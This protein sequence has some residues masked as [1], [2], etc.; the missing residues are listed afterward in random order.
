VSVPYGGP[1]GGPGWDPKAQAKADKAYRKA[2]RPF[3]KKKRFILPVALLALI[4]IGVASNSGGSSQT[5][6]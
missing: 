3:Y 1:P 6:H 5:R 4:V 2:Q